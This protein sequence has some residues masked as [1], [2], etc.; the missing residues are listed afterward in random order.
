MAE[1]DK[2]TISILVEQE[3]QDVQLLGHLQIILS[4]RSDHSYSYD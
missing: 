3:M 4:H 2:S 1:R